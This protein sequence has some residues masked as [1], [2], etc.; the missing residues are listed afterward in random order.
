MAVDSVVFTANS[1]VFYDEYIA[2]RIGLVPL[3]SEEALDKYKFSE[4]CVEAGDRGI[5]TEDCF[6]KLDLEAKN[7]SKKGEGKPIT[8]YSGDMK[9]SDPDVRP[10][11]DK[12]PIVILAPQQEVK[13]EAYARL[14]KGK[15]HAK[16]SPVSVAAHKYIADI[17]IDYS[18]CH[19]EEC[20]GACVEACPRQVLELK[21]G[22]P[23]VRENKIYDCTLCRACEEACPYEAIKVGWRK[24]EYI[25]TIESTGSLSPKRILLESVKILESKLD[26]LVNKLREEGVVR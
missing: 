19:S 7:E 23:V 22:K 9:T 12:I 16:W 14:G 10:V 17:K 8:L 20:G 1:S 21:D 15:E 2:H 3:R 18:K 24:D 11:Y 26:E 4:E 13:L 6:V 25:F 5:F